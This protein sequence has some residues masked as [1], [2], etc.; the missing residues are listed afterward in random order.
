[1]RAAAFILFAAAWLMPPPACQ[2]QQASSW[3]VYKIVDGLP[4]RACA[5]AS[6]GQQGV[7]VA[8]HLNQ[9]FISQLDGY[10]VT[11]LSAPPGNY[12]RVSQS[13]AGQLWAVNAHG[14]V[15]RRETNWVAHSIPGFESAMATDPALLSKVELCPVRQG[16]VLVLLSDRLMEFRSDTGK[17]GDTEL[18][19]LASDLAIGEFTGMCRARDGGLWVSGVRGIAKLPAPIRNINP[20]SEWAQFILPEMER[21]SG[22]R[23][24]QEAE[25]GK[26]SFVADSA[27]G[28]SGLPVYFD[29]QNWH[30]DLSGSEQVRFAWQGPD[31]GLWAASARAVTR[32]EGLT[33]LIENQEISPRQIFDVATELKGNFWLATSDGLFRYS[34]AIWQTP[35]VLR[36]SKQE[37]DCLAAD[38]ESTVW[39][40]ADSRLH[41]LKSGH[42]DEYML[43]GTIST[44][45][46]S[47]RVY[48]LP[49]GSLLLESTS[50]LWIFVPA[51]KTFHAVSEHEPLY[52]GRV[53]GARKDGAVCVWFGSGGGP[54]ESVK[55]YDGARFE[56]FQESGTVRANPV[57]AARRG[58]QCFR[59][60]GPQ[61]FLF[62]G[63]KRGSVARA[64]KRDGMAS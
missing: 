10:G 41:R 36:D 16:H 62:H 33:G 3:R 52:G 50:G 60:R 29:G 51:T 40:I 28:R 49:S 11:V 5:Y 20:Q 58:D 19:R 9:P 8:R 44:N 24:P 15:E 6:V 34:P 54:S 42:H 47:W 55:A 31:G 38:G 53:L 64:G 17:G 2:A 13:P 30:A 14:L 48:P 12:G 56:R 27:S 61:L 63:P 1:M 25:N 21:T 59:R 35:L 7:V 57:R 39:F 26:L 37:I 45:G 46:V 23:F 4:E 43:P 32:W 18:L 22:L